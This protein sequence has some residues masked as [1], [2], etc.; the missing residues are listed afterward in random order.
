MVIL[1]Q[2]VNCDRCNRIIKWGEPILEEITYNTDVPIGVMFPQ[3]RVKMCSG[4]RDKISDST[5]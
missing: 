4:C 5:N 1:F 3:T 2:D